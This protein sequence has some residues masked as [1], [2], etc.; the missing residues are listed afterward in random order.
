MEFLKKEL[1]RASGF[2]RY[3][4]SFSFYLSLLNH[5]PA[6]LALIFGVLAFAQLFNNKPIRAL[7]LLT[8]CFYTHIGIS[9]FFALSFFFYGLFYREMRRGCLVIFFCAII[10]SLPLLHQQLL[11]VKFI[12]R[13]G[14]NLME[15]YTSQIKIVDYILAF[16][17][18]III[19]KKDKR[20]RIF[21]A[22]FLAGLIFLAYPY[23]FFSAE[24]YLPVIFLAAFALDGLYDRVKD[25]A[26]LL[27]Y[28][29]VLAA[30]FILFLSKASTTAQPGS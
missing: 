19:F 17:G 28:T 8:L 12:S 2:F 16:F 20:Y 23:R 15:R 11:A 6:T 5:I 22:F 13:L 30:L 27:R 18:L 25:R 21:P 1:Q 3:A 9:W 24:G 29:P 4:S 7:L 26:F 14:V 10:L